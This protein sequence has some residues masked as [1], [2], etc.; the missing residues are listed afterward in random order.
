[1]NFLRVAD[2]PDNR[3][4]GMSRYV[5]FVTDELRASGHEV[6]LAFGDDLPCRRAGRVRRFVAP[7]AVFRLVK[8]RLR[9][10]HQ[11][12]AVEIHEPIAAGYALARRYDPSLP[13]LIVSVYGLEARSRASQLAYCRKKGLR[14]SWRQRLARLV[15]V[16]QA[17]YALRNADHVTVETEQDFD[18]L[19]SRIGV[20]VDRISFLHGAAGP[21]FFEANGVSGHSRAGILFVGTWIERKGIRDMV[22]ALV[23]VLDKHPGTPVT[24]AGVGAPAET[25]L[26]RFP[27]AYQ[28]RVRVIPSVTADTAL[29]ELYRSSAILLLPS[30]FE[31]QPLVL[32]EA[33]A[34]GL[35]IVAT[36]TCGMKDFLRQGENGLLVE[37]GDSEAL[38]A[39]AL[40]LVQNPELAARLGAAA[41]QKAAS[42]TWQRSAEQFLAA[43]QAAV[44]RSPK[45]R[46]CPCGV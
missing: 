11:Y 12:D 17:N 13:P 6:D 45:R 39:C 41:R 44:A 26:E 16:S 10:G 20:P 4:G 31:G 42:F 46:P 22:P 29:C 3:T 32:L 8:G 1:M 27:P 30:L 15:S 14:I 34:A 9:Q 43:A 38:T 36:N 23:E 19:Q 35:A 33:A 37:P 24:L 18:Y 21:E 5:H 2:I 28:S 40:R 25:V 7:R